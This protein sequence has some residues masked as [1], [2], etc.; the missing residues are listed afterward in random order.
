[1]CGCFECKL[2]FHTDYDADGGLRCAAR[3]GHVEQQTHGEHFPPK[4]KR[5]TVT[6]SCTVYCCTPPVSMRVRAGGWKSL[7]PLGTRLNLTVEC[8]TCGAQYQY[9]KG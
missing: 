5:R 8:A 6:G 7:W 1:M 3:G 4:D 2:H 9:A